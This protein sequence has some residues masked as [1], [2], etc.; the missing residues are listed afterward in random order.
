MIIRHGWP[1]WNELF[2]DNHWRRL[3]LGRHGDRGT[4]EYFIRELGYGLLPWVALVPAALAT[5][6]MRR[7]AAQHDRRG[8][9]AVYWL[10]A[11]WFVAGYAVVSLSMTKFHHYVLPAVPGLAIVIGCF[12]D[13]LL[14]RGQR[15]GA[16]GV[17]DRGAA[18][19]A[20]GQ[21][22]CDTKNASQH[23]LWLFS[24]DYIHSP[25][26]APG[27]T[28][29]DFTTPLMV[30]AVVFALDDGPV[31]EAA[32]AAAAVALCGSA[33]LFTW[34]LLDGYMRDVAPY[35]SQKDTI[36]SYYK[37]RRSTDEQ[38]IAYQ[39][40]WR[41]ET[42]Y[43]KNAIYEGPA[44]DRTVFDMDGADEKLKEWLSGTAASGCSSS[45]SAAARVGCR[46]CCPR[47]RA[48]RSPCSTTTTT[49]SRW[50]RP[51]SDRGGEAKH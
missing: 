45:S 39:M 32:C 6:A 8:R 2:G 14:A 18:V 10:G 23:F 37:A 7:S 24:Y 29:L 31:I 46:A 3:V 19:A 16:G 40:Y 36:A 11:I 38:L 42:F 25:Q 41:G 27:P 51:T 28:Q 47:A 17:A 9:Q 30:F 33:M 35:W 44:E 5:M 1:F 13:D 12:L 20:G 48:A 4:F 26:G 15:R 21:D 22:L 50:P 49:S 43:T 34:F